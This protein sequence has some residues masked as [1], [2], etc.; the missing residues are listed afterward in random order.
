MYVYGSKFL[1]L[2]IVGE[3]LLREAIFKT[4]LR[5]HRRK[6]KVMEEKNK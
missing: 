3:R 6:I 4:Q 2:N 5:R 1:D